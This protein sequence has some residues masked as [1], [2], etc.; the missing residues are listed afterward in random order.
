MKHNPFQMEC[1]GRN[2]IE[3]QS[4]TFISDREKNLKLNMDFILFEYNPFFSVT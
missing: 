2:G 4:L 3:D 1:K